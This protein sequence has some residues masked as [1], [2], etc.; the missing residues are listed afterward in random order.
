MS[1]PDN[2]VNPEPGPHR[3]EVLK[4]S[5]YHNDDAHF[6]PYQDGQRLTAVACYWIDAP[7]GGADAAADWAYRAFNTDL[8]QLEASRDQSG[9]ETTFL[10]ACVYRLLRLRSLS[11]GDVVEIHNRRGSQWLA[12]EPFAW[13]P[14]SEPSQRSG[15]ALTAAAVYQHL[16]SQRRR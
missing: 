16:A 2:D 11:I 4:V 5:I 15:Q 12:C 3:G 10:A 1:T 6:L 14:I 13:R 9:G 8:D 7:P